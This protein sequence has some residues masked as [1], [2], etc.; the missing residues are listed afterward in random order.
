[1]L[2]SAGVDCCLQAIALSLG[3]TEAAQPVSQAVSQ[4]GSHTDRQSAPP[5]EE[6]ASQSQE[7]LALAQAMALSLGAA[8]M[9]QEPFDEDLALARAIALSMEASANVTLQSQPPAP[10]NTADATATTTQQLPQE[11]E[12][13]EPPALAAAVA[14]LRASLQSASRQVRHSSSAVSVK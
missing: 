5:V 11:M 3:A 4:P 14:L 13:D 10:I 12:T 9:P 7:E 8:E 6:A 2:T 1:L